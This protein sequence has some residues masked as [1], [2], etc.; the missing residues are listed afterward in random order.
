MSRE[1]GPRNAALC[2]LALA[3]CT[4][5]NGTETDNPVIDFEAS[6]CKGG[7]ALSLSPAVA[8]T[9][10]ALQMPAEQYANLFCYAWQVNDGGTVTIDVINYSGGCGVTW[11][12]SEARV[13]GDRVELGI[14]NASCVVAGC[15]SCRYDL[16]FEVAGVMLDAP[17]QVQVVEQGCNGAPDD[18][19]ERVELPIDRE[20]QGT[21]CSLLSGGFVPECGGLRERPCM[22]DDVLDQPGTCAAGL[23]DEGFAC[24][25]RA[26]LD[27]DVCFTACADDGDCPLAI[28]SCQ[29][30]ACRLREAL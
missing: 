24:A 16:S 29:E 25:E 7:S 23:C 19:S 9:Q 27:Q 30:G 4:C 14:A 21:L 28:E 11:S 1:L 15:G 17:A 18:A 8:R 13:D 5:T 10:A 6:E 3:M 20:P 26:Y 2:A 12:L 22:P